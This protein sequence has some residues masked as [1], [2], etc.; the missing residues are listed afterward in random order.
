MPHAALYNPQHTDPKA[1]Y[2]AATEGAALLDRSEVGR[3]RVSGK[4]A[5]DLLNRLSSYKVDE[6]PAGTGAGTILTTNKGRVIDLLHL[7][8]TEEGLLML[9]SPGTR[10]QV[11]EWIDTYTFMEDA[12]FEDVTDSTAMLGLLG[13]RAADLLHRAAS[14]PLPVLE[15]YASATVAIG[16]LQATLLRTDTL[17]APGYDLPTYDLIVPLEQQEVLWRAL[18]GA[19]AKP[20]APD[21]FN[22]LRIEAGVPLHPWDLNEEVN[23]WEAALQDYIHLAKGC[24][25]GQEVVLR[26]RTYQKVQ[27]Y[28]VRLAFSSEVAEGAKLSKDGI[29]VGLVTSVAVHPAT[30]QAIGLGLVRAAHAS[31]GAELEAGDAKA[32]VQAVLSLVTVE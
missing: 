19:G 18:T 17:R 13:P 16:G 21:V 24:Y 28:L 1:K 2:S 6:M 4:D 12:V 10:R 26:L 27:R 20:I 23:P 25:I 22:A 29:G 15:R 11:A 31:E 32:V 3:F 5:L 9:T 30:G 14:G 7:F 8:A